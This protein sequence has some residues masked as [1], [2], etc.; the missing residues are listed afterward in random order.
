MSF[1]ETTR[2]AD[3][4]GIDLSGADIEAAIFTA[5]GGGHGGAT[6]A[7]LAPDG[8]PTKTADWVTTYGG[9]PIVDTFDFG[10]P[11]ADRDAEIK[12]VAEPEG[13]HPL[14]DLFKDDDQPVF[15]NGGPE[16]TALGPAV[17]AVVVVAAFALAAAYL[18][19]AFDEKEPPPEK[20]ETPELQKWEDTHYTDPDAMTGDLTSPSDMMA[21]LLKRSGIEGI[22]TDSVAITDLLARLGD[23]MGKVADLVGALKGAAAA[24]DADAFA[25]ALAR[26]MDLAGL[27]ATAL[28]G[29]L[30]APEMVQ[31]GVFE[32]YGIDGG[33][34]GLTKLAQAQEDA[35]VEVIQDGRIDW[36]DLVRTWDD[37]I[38]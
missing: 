5:T 9:T 15:A 10:Q 20:T 2:P 16:G 19:G 11:P 1:T 28:E 32:A 24:G 33:L 31:D 12:L 29:A 7:P 18:A 35:W 14:L 25:G 30:T 22:D 27:D 21:D 6:P 34:D 3:I 38:A 13:S 8:E 26:L 17:A 4:G 23:Q 36:S 37:E